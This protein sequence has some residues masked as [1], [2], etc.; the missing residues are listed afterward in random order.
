MNFF[1]FFHETSHTKKLT[2]NERLFCAIGKSLESRSFSVDRRQ[3]KHLELGKGCVTFHANRRSSTAIHRRQRMKA[4]ETLYTNGK[5]GSM[6]SKTS[7]AVKGAAGGR[8]LGRRIGDY[9]QLYALLLIPVALTLIYKYI[10]MYGIQIAFR[11]YKA[12][13]GI[14]G[15]RWVGLDWFRRF[16]SAPTCGRMIRNTVLLS[17]YSLLWGFCYPCASI[18]C[19]SRSISARYKRY[20]TRRTLSPLWLSAV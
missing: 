5:E 19:A 11:D 12:S 9:W 20:C 2:N 17:F 13:S 3:K 16:F 15:S 10:P 6:A 14:V 7:A 4:S 8:N 1:S 18:N